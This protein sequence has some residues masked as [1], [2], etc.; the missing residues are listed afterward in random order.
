MLLA[1]DIETEP[2]DQ[3]LEADQL[4]LG[5]PVRGFQSA[6]AE[7]EI[8]A[9]DRDFFRL[10]LL[11]GDQVSV[12]VDTVADA[13]SPT[14][15]V[16]RGGGEVM[17]DTNSGPGSSAL[18][19]VH[20][21]E[22]SG[23]YFFEIFSQN[24]NQTGNYD[25]RVDLARNED[26]SQSIQIESDR[27]YSNDAV[28]SANTLTYAYNGSNRSATVAGTL[29]AAENAERDEDTF[30][31]GLMNPGMTLTLST[32]TPNTSSVNPIVEIINSSGVR[33]I[34][35]DDSR[36]GFQGTI[37]ETDT[38]Y[39]RVRTDLIFSGSRYVFDPAGVQTWTNA[40]ANASAA[41][42]NLVAITSEEEATAI[43]ETM[44]NR[45]FWIGASD[46]AVEDN[47]AWTSGEPFSFSLWDTNQP[48]S[49][50][51]AYSSNGRWYTT[52]DGANFIGLQELPAEAGGPTE[53][54][55]GH[56]AQYVLDVTISDLVPP[57]VTAVNG[58]PEDGGSA[59]DLIG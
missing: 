20:T 42:G 5:S 53:S 1:G 35:T 28:T 47:F 12:A 16:S 6:F 29:M 40:Q 52:S 44:S 10:D 19:G 59:V 41:G 21:V 7:G 37:T 13:F 15:I 34:D 54:R 3:R 24:G 25:L 8:Q 11:A 33:V 32:S 17:R 50:D 2:N 38:Y 30:R 39:A 31:L 23:V 9:N 4:V 58:L 45:S 55:A 51:F 18:T 49:S 27:S 36:G 57:T 14:V 56:L 26:A 22:I 48:G 43:S 46:Q